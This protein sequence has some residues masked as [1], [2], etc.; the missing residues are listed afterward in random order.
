MYYTYMKT[1]YQELPPDIF[2]H[3][4]LKEMNREMTTFKF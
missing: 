2:W 3:F 1:D 4:V